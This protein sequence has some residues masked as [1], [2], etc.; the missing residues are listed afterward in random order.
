MLKAV[1][2]HTDS[3]KVTRLENSSAPA[4]WVE[5]QYCISSL[6]ATLHVTFQVSLVPNCEHENLCAFNRNSRTI[7]VCL[8][9]HMKVWGGRD[10]LTI[11]TF[12]CKVFIN[13]VKNGRCWIFIM[14]SHSTQDRAHRP[15]EAIRAATPPE[16]VNYS[17]FMIFTGIKITSQNETENQRETESPSPVCLAGAVVCEGSDGTWWSLASGCGLWQHSQDLPSLGSESD[18]WPSPG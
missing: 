6:E 2:G 10:S 13:T 16:E 9:P 12:L 4:F 3:A 18:S 5:T 8:A 17:G 11:L 14:W 1:P 15:L 7:Q